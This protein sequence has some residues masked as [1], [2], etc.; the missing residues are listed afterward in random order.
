ME[1]RAHAV[2]FKDQAMTLIGPELLVGEKAPDFAA[3]AKDL[4]SASL[5][6]F[7]GKV[8]V[9]LSVPSLD[10][11]VCDQETRRFNEEA[12]RL[13]GAVA[14]VTISMDLPFAQN[15]WC[16]ATGVDQVTLLSDYEDRE[17]GVNYGVYIKELGLLSRAVFIIDPQGILRYV[18]YVPEV[19]M[20]PD[21]DKAFAA[22]QA[23]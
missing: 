17:F 23:L 6:D 18:E 14:I 3:V 9:I 21:Y 13:N 4:S 7:L 22:I 15:R 5:R 8:V 2:R 1:E 19:G 11:P 10:T 12:A 16:G 20:H